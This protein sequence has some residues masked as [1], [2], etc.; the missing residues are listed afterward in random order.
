MAATNVLKDLVAIA[1]RTMLVM[2]IIPS[3]LLSSTVAGPS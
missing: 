1:V 3:I 2:V